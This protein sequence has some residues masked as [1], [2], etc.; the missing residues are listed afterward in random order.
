MST[1]KDSDGGNKITAK[2]ISD[3][4]KDIE[5]GANEINKEVEEAKKLV[6]ESGLQVYSAI[7]LKEAAELVTKVLKG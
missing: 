6:K 7:L 1:S 2:E 3:G 4:L 5:Q